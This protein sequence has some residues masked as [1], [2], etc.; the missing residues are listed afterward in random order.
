MKSGI[1]PKT[2]PMAKRTVAAKN[3]EI[4]VKAESRTKPE[5]KLLKKRKIDRS[6]DCWVVYGVEHIDVKCR[7]RPRDSQ[8]KCQTEE[9]KQQSTVKRRQTER[10]IAAKKNEERHQVQ[11]NEERH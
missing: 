2:G 7:L 5:K 11:K 4:G 6:F 9:K 8:Q 10:M 1:K 3:M